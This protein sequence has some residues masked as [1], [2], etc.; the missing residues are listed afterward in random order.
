MHRFK[1]AV[2]ACAL[3]A[4]SVTS[5]A[6]AA[7]QRRVLDFTLVNKTPYTIVELYVSP[8]KDEQ[9]GEDVLGKDILEPGK[10]VEITF[11][12]GE[13]TCIWDLK[14]VDEDEDE[15]EWEKFNLCE[16]SEITLKY[17]NGKPT[18]IIK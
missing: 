5:S 1:F 15:V 8:T 14:I 18:A 2:L 7:A 6:A 9:W 12:R 4:V 10:E 13:T 16:A 11:S 3:A 17:E